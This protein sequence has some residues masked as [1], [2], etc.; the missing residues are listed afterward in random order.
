MRTFSSKLALV[1]L[2]LAIPYISFSTTYYSKS[3]GFANLLSN[4][5]T[6]TDGTGTQPPD[7]QQSG[8]IF[9]LRSGVTLGLSGDWWIR[10]GVTLQVDGFIAVTNN[11]HDITIDGTVIFTNVSATQVSLTGGGNGN[12]F[13][14]S[15]N[16]TV[17]TANQNGLRGTNAS[18]PLTASGSINLNTNAS[19]EFIGSADQLTTGLPAT[20]KDLITN[21]GSKTF[22]SANT[23]VNGQLRLQSGVLE[24]GNGVTL[25]I[26]SPSAIVGSGF[27]PG[28]HINTKINGSNKSFVRVN[29]V[30]G[31]VTIPTGDGVNYLPV[32]IST[33]TATNLRVNVFAGLT[34]DGNPNGTAFSTTEK[35]SSVDAVYTVERLSGTGSYDLTLGWPSSLE[36]P[37]FAALTNSEI[38]IATNT[39]SAWS[40]P[41]GSGSQASNTATLTGLSNM[42]I[43]AVGKIGIPL[44]V[45]FRSITASLKNNNVFLNWETLTEVDMQKFEIER[46]SDGVL[47]NSIGERSAMA[48]NYSGYH[49][50]FIDLSPLNGVSYYRIRSVESDGKISF[51]TI[52]RISN[53]TVIGHS[54]IFYPNPVLNKEVNIQLSDFK[55]GGYQL[56]ITDINGRYLLNQQIQVNANDLNSHIQLPSSMNKGNYMLLLSGNGERISRWFNVQ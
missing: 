19:Y 35:M 20:V 44:Y 45:K 13:T 42:G 37:Q 24:I 18:L 6:N 2:L 32:T 39:G 22:V 4:W 43:F 49:Y 48:A 36:G 25:T 29:G 15:A 50:E 10:A 38:G 31:T 55:Q 46:S 53:G 8:D 11:N 41:M 30:S 1:C 12:N 23:T 47:F 27:G 3:S 52:L 34:Q 51:S 21:N 33:A 16:A 5:G 40:L 26:S 9:I 14:V 56:I 54:L 28:K 17:R 7:F